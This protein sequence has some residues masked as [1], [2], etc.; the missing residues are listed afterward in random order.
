MPFENLSVHLGEE[1]RLDGGGLTEKT[2]TRRRGGFCRELDATSAWNSSAS[3]PRPGAGRGGPTGG[4]WPV[5]VSR[6]VKYL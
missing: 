4:W 5:R 3:P 6:T 2:T 1:I